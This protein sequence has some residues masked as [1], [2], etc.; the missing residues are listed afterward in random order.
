MSATWTPATASP[1]LIIAQEDQTNVSAT[2]S[3]VA[4][5]AVPGNTVTGISY[6]STLSIPSQFVFTP[7]YSGPNGSLGIFCPNFID[8]FQIVDIKYIRNKVQGVCYHWA[9]LPADAE[10][11]IG[12]HPDPVNVK[13]FP[14]DVTA[15]FSAAPNETMQ[16]IIQ[17][18][19]NYT[20]GKIQLVAAVDARR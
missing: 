6:S 7:A 10:E 1:P 17:V 12:F 3:V 15:T 4:D 11:V 18:F 8:V 16:Y 5:S 14:I 9:D 2:I 20:L 19:A 13:N